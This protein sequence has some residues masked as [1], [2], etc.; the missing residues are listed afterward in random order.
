MPAR[1]RVSLTA[2]D[3]PPEALAPRQAVADPEALSDDVERVLAEL[4][5]GASSVAVYR[6]DDTRPGKF[7]F[8][9]R[10]PAAEFSNDYVATQYGGG[11]YK[12]IVTDSVQGPLNP[13]FFSVDR[14]IVGKAFAI[15]QP[16]T[17]NNGESTFKD[18][19]LE[20]LLARALT[21]PAP[22]PVVQTPQKDPLEYIVALAP[23]LKSDSGSGMNLEGLAA[24]MTAVSELAGRMSP[25]DGIAGVAANLLPAVE[26]L[27]SA[28]VV[29]NAPHRVQP[30]VL[31]A[32]A[33]V[34]PV[35]EPVTAPAPIPVTT[36][37]KPQPAPIVGAIV[38]A[39]LKPFQS[40][41]GILVN[42]ADADADPTVY[43]DVCVDQLM[44]N[45]DAFRSAVEA[46]NAGTLKDD[47]L[48][49]V[50]A[51][52]ETP[53]RVEFVTNLV[54][55][56]EEGLRETIEQETESETVNG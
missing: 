16:Q 23:L 6:E 56:V 52:K 17:A 15:T 12:I 4:G 18:R 3:V 26:K 7:D 37:P 11:Q 34:V 5:E 22:A 39:W 43:A 25:P 21:P 42:L 10:V 54:A 41:A 51:L 9:V 1:K 31:P 8:V 24:I 47:V 20:I 36:V 53:E 40:F 32:P 33:P 2:G 13:I 38:P 55:R 30:R 35:A 49:A 46:M 27:V 50:P 19:L 28:H 44:T 45:E 29:A 14:R 48:N